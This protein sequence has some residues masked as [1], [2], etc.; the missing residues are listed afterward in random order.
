MNEKGR[1][2]VRG[3]QAGT[4]DRGWSLLEAEILLLLLGL[5]LGCLSWKSLKK[6]KNQ[7]FLKKARRCLPFYYESWNLF[8][9]PSFQRANVGFTRQIFESLVILIL[10]RNL[11]CLAGSSLCLEWVWHLLDRCEFSSLNIQQNFV[12]SESW[13]VRNW[14]MLGYSCY[15][16]RF[17]LVE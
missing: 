17:V 14:K 4:A 13:R 7:A 11:L 9:F 10:G 1:K 15:F 16:D 5:F 2:A 8:I 6:R 12:K 3:V